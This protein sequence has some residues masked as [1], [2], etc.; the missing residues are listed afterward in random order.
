MIGRTDWLVLITGET[1]RGKEVI[2]NLIRA[3]SRR[4]K[5]P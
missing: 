2:A 3:D 5:E 4:A 1:G